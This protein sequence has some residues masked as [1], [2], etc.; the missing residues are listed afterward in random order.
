MEFEMTGIASIFAIAAVTVATWN[1]DWFPSG[2]AEHRADPKVEAKTIR[3][4]GDMLRGAFAAADPSGTNDIVL[5]LNEMRDRET[6]VA[7]A[8]AIGRTNL[9]LAVVSGYRRRDRFDQQQ[10]AILT[11]LPVVSSSWSRWRNSRDT[12]P[13]RGFVFAELV[14][15]GAVTSRVYAVHLK[16]N[17]G[18]TSAE[19]AESNRAKRANAISQILEQERVKRGRFAAPVVIAGDMNADAWK[20]EFREE[21]IFPLFSEAGFDNVLAALDE[22]DRITHPGRGKWQGSVLDYVFVRELRVMAPPTVHFS[23]GVS[24]HNPVLVVVDSAS[25][26]EKQGKKAKKGRRPK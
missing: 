18:Q 19:I 4:A 11:T 16:S 14:F 1:G 17:Y 8:N 9:S 2:R 6:V 22:E 12:T 3:R 23:A 24:D 20:R 10:D 21:R 13:P 7:L 25:E 26:K 5:C 15:P